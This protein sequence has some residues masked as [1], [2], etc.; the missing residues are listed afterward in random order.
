MLQIG[1]SFFD[2]VELRF[3][4]SISSLSSSVAVWKAMVILSGRLAVAL[5]CRIQICLS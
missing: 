4:A 1:S 3:R 2:L 5:G